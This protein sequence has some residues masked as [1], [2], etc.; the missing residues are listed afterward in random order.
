MKLFRSPVLA[1]LDGQGSSLAIL[2][3][4][5]S[6][7]GILSQI[8]R[9][10]SDN[11]NNHINLKPKSASNLDQTNSPSRFNS[12]QAKK[13]K[14]PRQLPAIN[15]EIDQTYAGLLDI[16]HGSSEHIK[17]FFFFVPSQTQR[18]AKDLTLWTNGGPGCSSLV[19]AF[20][21]NGP[22]MWD[23]GSETPIKN[24]YSWH[25]RSNMLYL[26]HPSQVGFSEGNVIVNNENQVAKF[27]FRFLNAWL[28]VFPE[29]A[30]SNLYL[31]GESYAARYLSYTADLI[32]SKQ[33]QL[34]LALK[35]LFVSDGFFADSMILQQIPVYPYV[36]KHQN[37][38]KFNTTFMAKL[39]KVDQ[40]CGYSQYMQK[41]LVY[42]PSGPLPNLNRASSLKPSVVKPECDI[43]SLMSA[44]LPQ[45][46]NFYNIL[47]KKSY[48]YIFDSHPSYFNLYSVRSAFNVLG[49]KQ[50]ESCLTSNASLFPHGDQSPPPTLTVLPDVIRKNKR[51]ILAHGHLDSVLFIQGA[52][53]S[54]QNLTW[55]G[56]QGFQN[57]KSQAF[58]VSSQIKGKYRSERGLTHIT[59]DNSGH[60][61]PHDEPQAAL[62]VLEYLLGQRQSLSS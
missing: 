52:E 43:A 2:V 36:L 8:T 14:M 30:N 17:L 61:F 21:E 27:I 23:Q 11:L 38:F 37:A 40:T 26:E 9:S 1:V 13:F 62:Q 31:T 25:T 48:D 60:M 56:A 44:A 18:G 32:Y 28:K 29:M 6:F 10:S 57:P 20:Q 41:Y 3:L 5:I 24:P 50:W 19:G 4:V 51:T 15:F 59:V 54:L 42:P 58:L 16:S 53:L 46:F 33:D 12:P 34:Q 49:H 22:I 7:T 35:G 55:N 47:K 45:D 39:K